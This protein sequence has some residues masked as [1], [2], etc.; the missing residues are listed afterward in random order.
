[1]RVPRLSLPIRRLPLLPGWP[2]LVLLLAGALALVWRPDPRDQ[3]RA[4][5]RSFAAGHYHAALTT[6]TPLAPKLAPARLRLGMVRAL[7]GEAAEAERALRA[8][9]LAGLTPGD[10]QLALLYLGR[11]LADDGRAELAQRTWRLIEDCRSAEACG[12]RGPARLLA[13]E[14]ALQR[15]DYPAAEAGFQ[16]AYTAGLPPAWVA[17]AR[18]RLALLRAARDPAEAQRLLDL[19]DR[20]RLPAN[21]LIAPLL[22]P[23]GEGPAQLRAVLAAPAQEQAQLLGQLYLS[24][25]LYGLAEAQFARIDPA[26][27]EA[28]GAAAYAAYTRWR[29]GDAAGGLARLE[30]LAAAYPDDPRVRTLLA[31]AYLETD[32]GDVARAAIASAAEARPKE[33]WV[34][35]AWASWYAA[36]RDYDQASLAYERALALAPQAE[37]GRYALLAAQFH[38]ATTYELCERGLPLAEQAASASADDPVA[39]TTLAAHRYHCGEL[40]GAVAAARAAQAAGSGPA[41]AYYLG[42]ALAALGDSANARV[43]L[44]QAADLAPASDWRRRAELVLVTLR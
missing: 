3:L 27:P 13:A 9:M 21:P 23:S 14:L 38:L 31:L 43:A 40:A 36:Q 33:P 37:R 19:T 22:P 8:A 11:T 6:L 26:A 29:A 39:L 30:A 35:L 5:D 15:G 16:A 24:L 10:Y 25:G 18:Y 1:M 44:I 17:A 42:A 7:R 20:A 32:A 2:G 4:I 28:R 34:E 12:Y 41:A